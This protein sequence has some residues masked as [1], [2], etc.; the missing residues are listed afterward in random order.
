[1]NE[2]RREYIKR[3]NIVL[4]FIENNLDT[5]LSLEYL[6]KKAHYSAYHFHRVFL[7]LVNESL[8][9]YVNRKRIERIAAILLVKPNSSLK[10]LAYKYGFNSDNSFSRA[11]KKY[12]GISPTKF[13]SEGKE[14]LSKIGIEPFSSEKYICSIDNIKQ[15]TKM[16][17]QITIK[18]LPELKLASISNIGNFEK[19]G[20][21]FQK[22]MEWGHQK[23][24]LDTSNFK[25]ITIYRDNPNITQT[26]KVRFS[27]CVTISENINTD[28]EINQHNLKKGIYSIGHFEIKAEEISKAWKSM[29]IWVIENGYEF[30][31]GDYFEMYH[32]DHKTH[33]EQKFII[34]ICIPLQK[35][36]NIKLG[37]INNLD[38]SKYKDNLDYHQLISYMKELRLFF[39]K[40]YDT[41]F[42]L[43]KIYQ[44][45]P[46]FSYFS[47]TTDE[48]KKQ[49]LKF[50]IIL[51]HKELYFSICL[52]GQN[53]SIRKKYW[54]IF[55]GSDWNKYHLAE[56][57]DNSLSIIDQTILK[58]P[59]FNNKRN[60]TERIE[61]ES[62]KF[63][64]DIKN[65][66]E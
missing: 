62:L 38:L 20:S 33:P 32:N 3:I 41:I 13:K 2:T 16:N 55:K 25:A 19:A 58:N 47:L 51:N 1:M 7:T 9:E 11:F 15:W 39:Q 17:A 42:K 22:L 59:D 35:T 49:K 28:G 24:V 36:E 4:D 18:E 31:D 8:N 52:S 53:K 6:S 14:L 44:G 54:K 23:R 37:E 40:E 61:K 63:I 29:S 48:L 30:R 66:L 45:A 57:I 34:D 27:A 5:K 26:S 10:N 43:G 12:Y 21:M 56:S 64:N 46:N 65:I 50:V 60:L